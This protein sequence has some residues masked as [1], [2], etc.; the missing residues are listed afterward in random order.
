MGFLVGVNSEGDPYSSIVSDIIG[1]SVGFGLFHDNDR[2]YLL[3][4]NAVNSAQ[5]T[6]IL[7]HHSRHFFRR[8]AMNIQL[9]RE[10]Y[11]ATMTPTATPIRL[12]FVQGAD[13]FAPART[14]K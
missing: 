1:C 7:K 10:I 2:F 9:H 4:V 11:Y 14:Y 3:F 6:R 8:I 13:S 5:L 12:K